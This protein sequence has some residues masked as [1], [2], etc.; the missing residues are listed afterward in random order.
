MQKSKLMFLLHFLES[1]V[2]PQP[3]HWEPDQAHTVHMALTGV[4]ANSA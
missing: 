3:Q 4:S 1:D 2:H